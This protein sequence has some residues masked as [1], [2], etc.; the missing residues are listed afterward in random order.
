MHMCAFGD[1]PKTSKENKKL[2]GVHPGD[3]RYVP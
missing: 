3:I 1:L 2:L